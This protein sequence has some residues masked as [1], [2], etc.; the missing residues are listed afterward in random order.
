MVKLY[1]STSSYYERI[2]GKDWVLLRPY[3]DAHELSCQTALSL[4][5]ELYLSSLLFYEAYIFSLSFCQKMNG[6]RHE[7]SIAK[8]TCVPLRFAVLMVCFGCIMNTRIKLYYIDASQLLSFV[9]YIV[10]L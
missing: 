2:H 4:P 3:E 10:H 8:N 7:Q 5:H 1:A 9:C 6:A